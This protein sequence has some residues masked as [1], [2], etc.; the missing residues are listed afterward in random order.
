MNRDRSKNTTDGFT[1]DQQRDHGQDDGARE[2]GK[3]TELASAESEGRIVGV[4][5]SV[6]IGERRQK[7]CARDGSR[8]P[9]DQ[10]PA[11]AVQVDVLTLAYGDDQRHQCRNHDQGA[12][13]EAWVDERDDRGGEH[14]D[15][16]SDRCL[17]TGRQHHR[18]GDSAEPKHTHTEAS[19]LGSCSR[20]WWHSAEW[21]A[22]SGSRAL[23]GVVVAQ[24][25]VAFQQRVRNRQPDGGLIGLGTSP[26]STI[27]WCRAPGRG[28]GMA[29]SSAIVYGCSGC[30]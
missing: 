11:G 1:A 15:P 23:G 19:M 22:T 6:S 17:Q 25:S 29:E 16:E 4:F 10:R 28:S 3:I 9:T 7:Q 21:S 30:R 8:H 27:R 26:R 13:N 18:P 24:M 14:P 12:G 5:A 20:G 2:S